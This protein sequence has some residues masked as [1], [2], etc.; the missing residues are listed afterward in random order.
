MNAISCGEK[1]ISNLPICFYDFFRIIS[2][3]AVKRITSINFQVR[4]IDYCFKIY[5]AIECILT[6]AR[7]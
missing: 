6:N 4:E 3:I 5:T 2:Y 1:E 7:H